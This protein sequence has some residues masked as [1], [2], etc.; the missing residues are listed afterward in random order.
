ML[1]VGAWVGM[2]PLASAQ[3]AA[4]GPSAEYADAV[5]A[6][7][8]QLYRQAT[9]AFAS[10]RRSH[11]D[12]PNA[13]EALYFEA[14][15]ALALGRQEDAVRLFE[16]LQDAYPSHPRADDAQLSLGRYFLEKGDAR[17]GQQ[18][19]EEIVSANPESPQAGRALYLLGTRAREEGNHEQ[20]L[21]YFQRAAE[22]T[23]DDEV[24]AAALVATGATQ[25]EME[26]YEDAASSF[27]ALGRRFPTSPY[28]RNLGTALGEVYYE[29]GRYERAAEEFR[30][31]MD[32]LSGETR[33]RAVF[34]LAESYTQMRETERA[35]QEYQK[36]IGDAPLPGSDAYRRPARY[37]LAWN[38][39]FGGNPSAAIPYFEQVRRGHSDDYALRATYHEA[40]ARLQ[41]GDL[42]G[43]Q[44]LFR[45]VV[46]AWPESR[47]A[48]RSQYEIGTIAYR[49]D[50]YDPAAAAFRSVLRMSGASSIRGQAAY[51]LGNAYLAQ[52]DL[53][54][55]LEA[56]NRAISQDAAPD[57][58]RYDV[59]FRKAWA[60]YEDEQYGAA[61]SAFAQLGEQA[62]RAEAARDAL[63]WGADSYLQ[64]GRFAEA[65]RMLNRYLDAYPDGTHAV[66]AHYVLGWTHFKS[67]NYAQAAGAFQTFLDRY[68]PQDA[69]IPY[70][71]DA[72]LRLADSYYA[73]KR[74]DEAV[75][76]YRQ[77][78]GEGS[79][80]AAYQAGQ[81]LQFAGRSDEAV[82][83]L[84]SLVEDYPQSPWRQEALYRT[85]LIHFQE[86]EYAEARAAYR[87]LLDRYPNDRY[88]ARA[89]YGVGDTYYNAGEMER[90][91]QTYRRVLE[92]Y[93]ESETVTDAASSIF[94]AL[95]A[96]GASD[97]AEAVVDSFAAANPDADIVSE[98][99]FRRAE[100]AYQSG[101]RDEAL[102]LFR[103]FTRTSNNDALLPR[104]Y[105]YLGI[106]YADRDEADEAETYL[107]QLVRSYPDSDR[108]PEAA[109]RLGDIYLERDAYESALDAY[110][111]AAEGDGTGA[112]LQAQARYGQSRALIGL[113]R[114]DDAETLLRRIIDTNR[115]GPLLASARL[116]L[117]RLYADQGESTQALGLYR[118]VA[119]NA[120]SEAGAESL[121]RLGRLLREQGRY[122][123]AIRELS[124][125]PSLFAGYPEWVARSLLEQARAHRQLGQTG[126]ANELYDRVLREY[127]GTSFAQ[128]ARD[129][130]ATL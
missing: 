14:R 74:Y 5:E 109:L 7:E 121:Y 63:F 68:D 69:S 125:M 102:R 25:V 71:Q 31:R 30:T 123:D 20:A 22:R 11:P 36:L 53:D 35:R 12:H 87:Q 56:Y 89:L 117:A 112:E 72:R 106:I 15:A 21:S 67:G 6:Y 119:D 129:E 28:A 110:R 98:L 29:L 77:V 65:Q 13:A 37:G 99:R 95:N 51:W 108:R 23:A 79:D 4:P 45:E 9:Q 114:T 39:W 124:R 92:R 103:S 91:A 97:Q 47:F 78:D 120:R 111:T 83:V 104:A 33:A 41:T 40:I 59:Q 107:R 126:Q 61:A 49:Q 85:G 57:S 96:A 70:A 86:Q 46:E 75:S 113:G 60:Q 19:L 64:T 82:R 8:Q 127:S 100:A 116:G 66:E 118:Q 130:Q 52:D 101:D 32:G 58:L 88:A 42:S 48:A 17:R 115:G 24:A 43:A 50:A 44:S 16:R 1:L 128:T 38:A 73:Q 122:R 76:A 55:A 34:L 94:F 2:A 90:A 81:A 54:R 27:E 26:R 93:P 18:V 105:Y 84:R 80:Y 10:F 3:R 62:G